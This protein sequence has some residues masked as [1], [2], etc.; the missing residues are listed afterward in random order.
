MSRELTPILCFRAAPST[1]TS[2]SR[3]APSALDNTDT[4][5]EDSYTSCYSCCPS[6]E[7]IGQSIIPLEGRFIIEDGNLSFWS[8]TPTTFLTFRSL[9]SE[10]TASARDL[11]TEKRGTLSVSVVGKKA[12]WNAK[13]KLS[14][15]LNY[16]IIT[17]GCR[18]GYQTTFVCVDATNN[19]TTI[20]PWRMFPSSVSTIQS[21]LF[22]AYGE[23][24]GKL[25][26]HE[27]RRPRRI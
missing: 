26:F 3:A 10:M 8:K 18:L 4:D 7:N 6:N 11:G 17:S 21:M 20:H 16:E 9:G 25:L 24:S 23:V 14:P 1:P 15:S 19:D 12:A 2:C 5:N 27:L 13:E 22:Y